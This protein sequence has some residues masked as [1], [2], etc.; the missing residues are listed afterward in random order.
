MDLASTHT[1]SPVSRKPINQNS[2][3][4]YPSLSLVKIRL[5]HII[6]ALLL[7]VFFFFV[8]YFD[9]SDQQHGHHTQQNTGPDSPSSHPQ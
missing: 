8:F 6:V 7:S 2:G 1:R 9:F 5:K 3:E 4:A